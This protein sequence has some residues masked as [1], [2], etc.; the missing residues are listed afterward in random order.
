MSTFTAGIYFLEIANAEKK[1]VV[2]IIKK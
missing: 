2:K 1:S